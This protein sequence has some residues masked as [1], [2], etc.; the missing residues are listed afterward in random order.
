MAGIHTFHAPAVKCCALA[1]D[2][3]GP[4]AGGLNVFA[5]VDQVDGV[6]NVVGGFVGFRIG[7]RAVAVEIGF[8]VLEGGFP[9]AEEALHIPVAQN[10]S[11]RIDIDG[12][13]KEI[14]DLLSKLGSGSN[15]NNSQ[16]NLENNDKVDL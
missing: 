4:V 14:R 8:R 12:E 5:Q 7:Q 2:Q 10:L 15:N 3:V 13:I 6:P 1:Q 9:E 16:N 11:F